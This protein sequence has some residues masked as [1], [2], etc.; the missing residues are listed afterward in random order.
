MA[1]TIKVIIQGPH[2]IFDDEGHSMSPSYV[3]SVKDTS[4]IQQYISEG[5]ASVVE[6]EVA[7]T[8]QKPSTPK[9]LKSQETGFPTTQEN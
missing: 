9:N 3:Y 4:L 7:E 2:P 5:L 6:E 8:P 1:A